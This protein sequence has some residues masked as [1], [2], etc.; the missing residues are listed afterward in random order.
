LWEIEKSL[1][2]LV[3]VSYFA[4]MKKKF[5]TIMAFLCEADPCSLRALT[6]EE[7]CERYAGDPRQMERLLYDNFGMSGEEII[8][9]LVKNM[10]AIY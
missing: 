8:G 6:F 2:F 1:L 4:D 7:I 5:A 10:Q 9:Q 3:L